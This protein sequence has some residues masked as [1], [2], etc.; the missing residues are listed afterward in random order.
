MEQL[1]SVHYICLMGL[2]SK[3]RKV[4]EKPIPPPPSQTVDQFME[5]LV[6][7][8]EAPLGDL[9][10]CRCSFGEPTR[11]LPSGAT[12]QSIVFSGHALNIGM[13]YLNA[14]REGPANARARMPAQPDIRRVREASF[15]IPLVLVGLLSCCVPIF[16][17]VVRGVDNA[18]CVG[19]LL[20][21]IGRHGP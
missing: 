19:A 9:P 18:R 12:R 8:F 13:S 2:A 4:A 16:V 10:Q 1:A 17:A 7:D 3:A 14:A 20:A 5:A 21:A 11:K 15:V 6:W